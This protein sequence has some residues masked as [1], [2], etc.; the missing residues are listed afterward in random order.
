MLFNQ[1]K[2]P[3]L[4]KLVSFL[5]FFKCLIRYYLILL[6]I[7]SWFSMKLGVDTVVLRYLI[8]LKRS[9]YSNGCHYYYFL[10]FN[11][12]L[13]LDFQWIR[14]SFGCRIKYY[15][16]Y[17]KISCYSDGFKA[18]LKQLKLNY[19]I[20]S[21]LKLK[22]SIDSDQVQLS[23][24]VF[25]GFFRGFFFEGRKNGERAGNNIKFTFISDSKVKKNKT[26]K[27]LLKIIFE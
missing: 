7:I 19:C 18:E 16:Y 9:N 4:L 20:I 1:I 23:V 3:E 17:F 5:L 11:S 22:N 8:K 12:I 25:S 2:S 15:W 24:S 27:K 21:W 13:F 6:N 10:V 14:I 26:L